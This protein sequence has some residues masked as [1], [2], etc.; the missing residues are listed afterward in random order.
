MKD[1]LKR[2]LG[3]A[4][5]IVA[6]FV[7][8]A[9]ASTYLQRFSVVGVEKYVLYQS[10][11]IQNQSSIT[12][13]GP[14]E[15]G[16]NQTAASATLPTTTTGSN[17][18]MWVPAYN[19][20]AAVTQGDVLCSSNTGTGY[21]AK[22]PATTDLTS[23]VGVAAAS[24]ASGA[25]GWMVPRGGG[26]AVVHTTGTVNI[27]DCL[28]ST[29]TASGYLTGDTTPTTGA[30]VATAMSAGTASGGSVLAIMH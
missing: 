17:F 19:V 15:M 8:A 10:G 24:I 21:V 11:A 9:F 18:G 6:C 13:V 25:N 3:I 23:V 20:G 26:Y 12:T 30:D 2:K 27:G 5:G 4:L 28:V 29:I 7:V 16:D 1:F 14:I 22:C